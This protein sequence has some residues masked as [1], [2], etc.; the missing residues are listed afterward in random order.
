MKNAKKIGAFKDECN[1]KVPQEFIGL[2]SKMYSL[3]VSEGN[4]KSTAKGI[5]TVYAK[6]YMKHDVYKASLFDEQL[7]SSS[8]FVINSKN[9][10]VFTKRVEKDG[11]SPYDD[12]K[13]LLRNKESTLA[14]GHWRIAAGQV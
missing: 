3:K 13:F 8:F 6:K 10:D 14:Y 12:K 7:T 2:R 11:L 9:H 1:G 5:K 4:V